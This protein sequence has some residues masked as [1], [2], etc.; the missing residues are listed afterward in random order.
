[1][2][3]HFAALAALTAITCFAI[4]FT[5]AASHLPLRVEEA[6]SEDVLLVHYASGQGLGDMPPF[7]P[8]GII[9]KFA[10]GVSRAQQYSL[11]QQYECW[12]DRSCDAGDFQLVGIPAWMS[13]QRMVEVFGQH[14][15]IE[16]AELNYYA[17]LAFVP[18]DTFYSDQWN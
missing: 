1:M 11:A 16:Y 7:S 12:I 6:P 10:P 18:D 15:E 14:E 13:P 17:R 5:V 3:R 2:A 9:V 8:E 4:P